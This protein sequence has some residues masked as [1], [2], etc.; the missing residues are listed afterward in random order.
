V[1]ETYGFPSGHAAGTTVLYALA[2]MLALRRLRRPAARAAAV[3]FAVFMVLLVCWS[4][5]YLGVHYPSD[6]LAGAAVGLLWLALC[7]AIV[8]RGSALEP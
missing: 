2:A 4:R 6:V 3:A 8:R 7:R 1:L 5:V